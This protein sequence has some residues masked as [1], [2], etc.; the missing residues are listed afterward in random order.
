MKINILLRTRQ[1]ICA[2]AAIL[3]AAAVFVFSPS[4]RSGISDGIYLCISSVIPSL[5]IF[6]AIALFISS[7][8]LAALAGKLAEPVSKRLFGINGEQAAVMLLSFVSGYP[9]GARLIA[10]LYRRNRI[11]R[12][13]GCLMLLYSVNAGPAFIITA[14]G[15][16]VMGSESD[17]VRLLVSHLSASL[18]MAA[19]VGFYI[20]KSD[21]KKGPDMHQDIGMDSGRVYLSDVFVNSVSGAASAMISICA[22]VVLFSGI[23]GIV[24]VLPLSSKASESVKALLEVTVGIQ[25]CTRNNIGKASFLLGFGGI[26]VLFQ[27]ISS[28]GELRPSALPLLLSRI[29]HGTLSFTVIKL[30]EHFF[31]RSVETVSA[32]TPVAGG[33]V[34]TSPA[35]CA[36]LIFLSFVL[37]FY[38]RSAK[39][40][41]Q[42]TE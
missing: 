15:V 16:S 22:F 26:S 12:E 42:K 35:A 24:S 30:T 18:I 5:F 38:T 27:V 33:A 8:G 37:I 23:G 20:K 10:D 14:V 6:T 41:V 32:G 31:P 29:V 21:S 19:A 9:V 2:L 28:A 7:S 39:S 11:T 13:K 17:G 40:H 25:S 1:L 4:V 36:A 3:S 34:H